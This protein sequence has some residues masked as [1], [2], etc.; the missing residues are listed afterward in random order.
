MNWKEAVGFPIRIVVVLALLVITSPITLPITLWVFVM[1]PSDW[2]GS[3]S[4]IWHFILH[5]MRFNYN[6]RP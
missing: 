6:D 3:G 1:S 5:G 4:A 2:E